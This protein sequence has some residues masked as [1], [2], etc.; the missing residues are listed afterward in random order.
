[1]N[2]RVER[3]RRKSF[4][5]VPCVSVERAQLMTHFYREN[6]YKYSVPVLRA[7]NF[8]HLCERK[9][10]Y[11]GEDEL[12]VGERGPFP[13]AVPTYPELT[14][15]SLEDLKILDSRPMTRYA[16]SKETMSIYEREIIPFWRGR[17]LREHVFKE[18]PAEWRSAYE[19]GMFTEF[20]E[21][22]A[23]G[24]TVLDGIIYRKGMVDFKEEIAQSLANLDYLNDPEATEKAEELKAMAISCDAAIT[25]AERHAEMAEKMADRETNPERRAELIKIAATCRWVPAHAPRDF[26]EALQMYWFVHL[27]TVTELNGW[28]SMSPGHLDQHLYPFYEKDLVAN[29]LNREKAKELL[30]CFWI[31]FN[32]QPAPPKV[33]VTAEESGTYNDFTNINLAG[34]KRDG[35]DGVNE[36]SYLLL[37][38]LDEM[39][40]LQPQANV[41]VSHKTPERFLKAACRVIRK[42]S[43]YPSVFNADEVIMEQLRI[44]K[45]LEDARE[46]GTSGCIETGSFGKEAFILTGYLNVP[47][48]L[49]V[50]LNNGLDPLTGHTVGLQTGGPRN[51]TSFDALYGAFEK[52]LNYCVDLKIRVNNYI[53]RM[54][55]WYA[56]APFLSV[57]I[58]D[59]IARGK[60]YNNGGP[61][62]NA[63]YIQC[64][65][66][67]TITDSLSAIKKHVFEEKT[68]AMDHLL[69]ALQ[70]NFDGEESL[71]LMLF[72]K[73]PFYGNDDDLA[74]SIMQQVYASLFNAIDGKPNTKGTEYHLNMLSTT[75]HVYFG[76]MLG[77]SANGR[78]AGFPISDG[79]S[80]SHGA[81]RKGPTAVIKSLGKMDQVKSGGTLLNQRFT[82]GVLKGETGVDSMAH[83]IRTYFNLNGHHVQFNVVDT[84]TLRRAQEVPDEYRNL[85]VRVAGYSDYFVD[86]DRH[87]QEEIIARTEHESL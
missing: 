59:C 24:H 55:A 75:C 51:F 45:T 79:T 69:N 7:L 6:M 40:L 3:L 39:Q 36:V 42:G 22:R 61:R 87:H 12:I 23:P 50:T 31:K 48:I 9:T 83:L 26:W 30:Q 44:G 2:E 43:G 60:D 8:K 33:G 76:R 80:P 70:K 57:V 15:H 35:S 77:A 29:T 71:R 54:Y 78:L 21:Q 5:T 19:V 58:R 25:F 18:A 65:G 16:V 74:D 28:D 85:L 66:I 52:Q 56:P 86:L 68:V 10:L 41:Q 4:E 1:M 64:C 13:K 53:E 63:N 84:A 72:N 46:G 32:N 82:P 38:V 17:N 27:G 20:M 47:K 67:G 62:Y 11:I 34:L 49:E 14:C 37:E 81:D 73:T